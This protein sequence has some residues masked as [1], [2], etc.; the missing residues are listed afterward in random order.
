MKEQPVVTVL[1][2]KLGNVSVSTKGVKGPA[3][4]E[5]TAAFEKLLG[6][7]EVTLTQDYHERPREQITLQTQKN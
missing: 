6:V 1:V 7:G 4:L 5:L 3:C 2:D